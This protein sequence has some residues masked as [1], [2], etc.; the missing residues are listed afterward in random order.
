MVILSLQ[1]MR[2]KY[3]VHVH[4]YISNCTFN[5]TS[6]YSKL[7]VLILFAWFVSIIENHYIGWL[8]DGYF[9]EVVSWTFHVCGSYVVILLNWANL[10][11]IWQGLL[12]IA[13]IKMRCVMMGLDCLF[14]PEEEGL[15]TL[16]KFKTSFTKII[17]NMRKFYTIVLLCT[18]ILLPSSKLS[19]MFY[20]WV[21]WGTSC[22]DPKWLIIKVLARKV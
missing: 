6:V 17:K 18:C 20:W 13:D 8:E 22:V 19:K 21:G 5:E 12:L 1:S 10:S 4:F 7:W 9:L 16:L 14:L 11:R 2:L 15:E 3:F